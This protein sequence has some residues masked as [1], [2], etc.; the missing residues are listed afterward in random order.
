MVMVLLDLK[1]I[2]VKRHKELLGRILKHQLRMTIGLL[3]IQELETLHC[4]A[5][6]LVAEAWSDE[7][8]FYL[9]RGARFTPKAGGRPLEREIFPTRPTVPGRTRRP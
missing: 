2:T 7:A 4:P 3:R 5:T 9:F 6:V 8:T 1:Y